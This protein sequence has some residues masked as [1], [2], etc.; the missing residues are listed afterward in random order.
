MADQIVFFQYLTLKIIFHKQQVIQRNQIFLHL[1]EQGVRN[2]E[3]IIFYY[4]KQ[5][6]LEKCQIK[7]QLWK[8]IEFKMLLTQNHN[9]IFNMIPR[10][11]KGN[12][13]QFQSI[14]LCLY[15]QQLQYSLKMFICVFQGI[16]IKSKTIEY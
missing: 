10:K 16:Y 11:T 13:F 3:L 14:S 8:S 12:L 15:S 9:F 2:I 7:K 1:Q 4:L 6:N 5:K